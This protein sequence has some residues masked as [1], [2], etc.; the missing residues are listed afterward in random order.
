MTISRTDAPIEMSPVIGRHS[1]GRALAVLLTVAAIVSAGT[2][3][4]A[5]DTLGS[6]RL[7]DEIVAK[8]DRVLVG[9]VPDRAAP[10]TVL[11]TDPPEESDVPE[12]IATPATAASGRIMT[13]SPAQ[14]PVPTA[15]QTPVPTARRVPVD[16]DIVSDHEAVF[17]HELKVTWCASAGVQMALAVLRLGDTSH[18]FQRTIQGRV[19]EC[20]A[21]PPGRSRGR[22]HRS[23]CWHGA[24]PTRG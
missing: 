4:I 2:F 23:S 22:T 11:V 8:V 15:G 9:P 20:F 14:T 13:P 10:V 12:P 17:A 21:G 6:G 24:A 19:G 5:T 18:A 7:V 16:V 1:R 3:A